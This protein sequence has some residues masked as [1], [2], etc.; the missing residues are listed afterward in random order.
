MQQVVF[1]LEVRHNAVTGQ[2]HLHIQQAR[3]EGDILTLFTAAE[4]LPVPSYLTLQTG[5]SEHIILS[6]EILEYCNHSCDPNVFFDTTA[7]VFRTLKSI[8]AGDE[9]TFFYPSTEWEMAQ[10][11]ACFCRSTQCL[12]TIQGASRLSPDVLSRYQLT[13]FIVKQLD[14]ETARVATA[15][16]D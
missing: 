4:I 6:P 11:F 12:G 14:L 8:E 13:D 7:M 2:R 16:I 3:A 5:P 1:P 10:P 15:L 9:L